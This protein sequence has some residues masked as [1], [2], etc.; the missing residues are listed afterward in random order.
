M[1]SPSQK[2]NCVCETKLEF[3]LGVIAFP[4]VNTKRPQTRLVSHFHKARV[5]FL[6]RILIIAL[7]RCIICAKL[8]SGVGGKG[9]LR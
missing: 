4:G 3:L 7:R 8:E 1:S 5:A 2:A 6:L 9:V